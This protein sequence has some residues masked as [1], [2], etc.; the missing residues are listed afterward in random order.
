M[1]RVLGIGG[2]FLKAKDPAV[3]KDWYRRHLGLA[4][5]EWGG[6]AFPWRRG[7]GFPGLTVWSLF[8][9]DSPYFGAERQQA[10][11][12][13]VVADLRG[14]LDAL[15][16]EGCDVDDKLEDSEY[17]LF[18]WVTDPEGNRLELWQ[19][20]AAGGAAAAQVEPA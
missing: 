6:L 13:Y 12:N 2:V 7:D 11:V 9:G 14:L 20:P 15:R 5:E 1:E 16:A 17:G 19:P 3:L 18:G 4:I 10:M 8:P